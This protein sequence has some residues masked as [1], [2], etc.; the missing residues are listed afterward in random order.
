MNCPPVQTAQPVLPSATPFL[1]THLRV[2]HS[3]EQR[4]SCMRGGTPARETG[5]AASDRSAGKGLRPQRGRAMPFWAGAS[6]PFWILGEVRSAFKSCRCRT[7]RWE[8]F[9]EK[10]LEEVQRFLEWLQMWIVGLGFDI[11]VWWFGV[12]VFGLG[13]GVCA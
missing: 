7:A 3:A 5:F 12:F 9:W 10:D 8:G 2:V 1:Q 11:V 6:V 4:Q 13:Y